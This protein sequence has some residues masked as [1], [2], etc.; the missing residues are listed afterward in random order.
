MQKRQGVWLPV[1]TV[2]FLG[3]FVLLLLFL[4]DF[5][6][7]ANELPH[8]D[9]VVVL[10]G[11][12]GRI[13]EGLRL[14]KEGKGMYLIISGV[15]GRSDLNRIFPGRDLKSTVDTARII[16]DI[17]SRSTADNAVNV[18]RIVEEKGLN[19]LILVTS[20]YHM[21]RAFTIFRKA[22]KS[23]VEIYR[24]PVKGPNFKDD[25]WNDINS[26]KLVLNEFI[27]AC[28]FQVWQR[29]VEL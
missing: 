18:K 27:K 3:I 12:N 6:F 17:E 23:E 20:N 1:I 5:R 14:F 8:A 7:Y 2:L 13:E 4:R 11:G 15:E 16:L 19:S 25:W 28:W 26:F 21:K 22:M 9:A 24:H 29:W 10:T